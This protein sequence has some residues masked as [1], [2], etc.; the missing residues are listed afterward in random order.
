MNTSISP[1]AAREFIKKDPQRSNE[2]MGA[3][4]KQSADQFGKSAAYLRWQDKAA[5]QKFFAGEFQQFTKEAAD[6]LLEVGIIKAIPDLT[7]LADTSYIK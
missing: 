2:I 6:L 7:S 3:P 4:T 5:N 1:I